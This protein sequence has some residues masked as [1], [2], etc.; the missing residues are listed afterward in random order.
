MKCPGCYS[1]NEEGQKY[2][3]T[4][5]VRLRTKCEGCGNIILPS[6]RFCGACGLELEIGKR[7]APKREN[8]VS[9]HKL[10]TSL[11]LDI[12]GHATLLERLDAEKVKDL[13]SQIIDEIAQIVI[14]YE[15]HIETSAGDQVMAF[16]G[17]PRAH[18]DDPVRAVKTASEIHQVVRRISL[19]ALETIGQPLWVQIGINTGLTVTGLF[20]FEKAAAHHI[21]GDAVNATSRLCTLAKP[22]ETLVGQATYAQAEG[23]FDFQPLEPVEI[24]PALVSRGL[25]RGLRARPS[26]LRCPSLPRS[27]LR[28]SSPSFRR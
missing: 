25:G 9:E 2:C 21:A 6:D 20:D 22:G 7:A 1:L 24:R 12:S 15:G 18:E 14:K 11:F 17:V 13:V 27:V 26:F 4:C 19:K 23:F 8:I 16:F 3:R 10:I 5:G 28:A